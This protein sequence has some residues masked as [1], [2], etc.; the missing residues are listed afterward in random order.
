M[1]QSSSSRSWSRSITTSRASCASG[2]TR[3]VGISR[4]IWY[5]GGGMIRCT[6]ALTRRR[7]DPHARDH[8]REP[9]AGPRVEPALRRSACIRSRRDSSGAFTAWT[10]CRLIVSGFG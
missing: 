5:F 9:P 8:E 4:S 2:A 1:V 7:R 3:A 10:V 6:S